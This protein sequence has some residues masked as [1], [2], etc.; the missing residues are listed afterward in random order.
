MSKGNIP[1]N[2]VLKEQNPSIFKYI[3]T[4]ENGNHFIPPENFKSYLEDEIIKNE[5]IKTAI[6]GHQ[7]INDLKPILLVKKGKGMTISPSYNYKTK[8]PN[9]ETTYYNHTSKEAIYNYRNNTRDEYNKYASK[10]YNK[11]VKDDE[12]RKKK[13]EKQKIYN[14]R[15]REKKKAEK[16]KE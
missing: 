7:F 8:A 12:W 1:L 3:K 13:N 9:T 16:A 2:P 5:K 14:Q 4:D 6:E 11:K 15:Y 10:Y